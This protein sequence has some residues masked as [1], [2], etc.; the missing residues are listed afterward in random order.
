MDDQGHLMTTQRPTAYGVQGNDNDP[1]YPGPTGQMTMSFSH[2]I[3][4]LSYVLRTVCTNYRWKLG[5]RQVQMAG[6]AQGRGVV[7]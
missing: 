1:G 7:S 3:L 2:H 6:P 5:F 4:Y